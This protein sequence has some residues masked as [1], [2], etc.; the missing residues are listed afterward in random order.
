MVFGPIEIIS[1]I[2]SIGSDSD[3]APYLHYSQP[4]HIKPYIGLVAQ[5][6]RRWNTITRWKTNSHFWVTILYLQPDPLDGGDSAVKYAY[7]LHTVSQFRFAL[8]TVKD[9]DITLV[10]RQVDASQML[11]NDRATW[12]RIFMHCVAMLSEYSHQ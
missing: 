4:R 11:P 1:H 12:S 2:F 10:W 7:K 5:V 9:S 8:S 3:L 6:C